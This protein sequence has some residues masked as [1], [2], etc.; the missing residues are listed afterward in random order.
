MQPEQLMTCSPQKSSSFALI[1]MQKNPWVSARFQHNFPSKRTISEGA[2]T[3]LYLTMFSSSSTSFAE[4]GPT[5][6]TQPPKGPPFAFLSL[7]LPLPSWKKD[8]CLPRKWGATSQISDFFCFTFRL[9]K[10]PYSHPLRQRQSPATLPTVPLKHPMA[11]VVLIHDASSDSSN[12]SKCRDRRARPK[13][14][15]LLHAAKAP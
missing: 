14:P 7:L 8:I 13:P 10:I 9:R 12:N 3:L 15:R 4:S 1:L 11:S 5:L 6:G 2:C